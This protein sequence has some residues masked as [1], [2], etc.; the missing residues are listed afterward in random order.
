MTNLIRWESCDRY[1]EG[2]LSNGNPFKYHV[3]RELKCDHPK[4]KKCWFMGS[5]EMKVNSAIKIGIEIITEDMQRFSHSGISDEDYEKA[6][7]PEAEEWLKQL[8]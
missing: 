2:V 6:N 5:S 3:T 4:V 1:D 8:K 7:I